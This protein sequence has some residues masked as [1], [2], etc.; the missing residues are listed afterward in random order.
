MQYSQIPK[1]SPYQFVVDR[2]LMK[3]PLHSN[4]GVSGVC[5]SIDSVYHDFCNEVDLMIISHQ[6]LKPLSIESTL[7][8]QESFLVGF[9]DHVWRFS[10]LN[11][12]IS[13]NMHFISFHNGRVGIG[14]VKEIPDTISPLF[15]S[16]AGFTNV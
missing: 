2:F 3:S 13:Y 16:L 15:Y 8:Y 10:I 11:T 5:S 1:L 4:P 9:G 7:E 6:R 14:K 12:D